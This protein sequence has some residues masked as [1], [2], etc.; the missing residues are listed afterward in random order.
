MVRFEEIK[1]LIAEGL[2]DRAIVRALRCRREKVAEI[3]RGDAP[4]PSRPKFL[5][6][7]LWTEQVPWAEVI[8]ELSLGHPLKMI[9]EEKAQALTTYPN[10]WKQFYRKYPQYLKA[11]VTLREFNPGERCEVDY[12]GDRIEWL[13]LKNGQVHEAAVFV[14]TLGFSQLFF[15][16]AA[17]DMKSRNWLTSHRRMFEAFGGV[18]H[19]TVPDCLKQGVTK[20]HLY[21]P[22]LNRSYAELAAHYHTAIIPARPA[23]PKDKAI[24]EGAVKILMRYFKW[25]HRRRTFTSISEVNQALAQVVERINRKPHTRFRIS[26]LERFEK[27]ERGQLKPLPEHPFDSIEWKEARL[28]PDCHLSVDSA[29]Y[30]A[31][32]IHRNKKLRVK[33]T[34]FHVEIYCELERIAIHKRDRHKSGNRVTDPEHLPPNSRAYR[35]ATP[36]HLL[37]QARFIS[38][39]LY[40]LVNE[41]FEADALGHLRRVQGLIRTCI[42]EINESSRENALPRIEKAIQQMRRFQKYRVSYFQ[43][44]LRHLKK[45]TKPQEDREISRLPDNPMLRYASPDTGAI[46]S[47]FAGIIEESK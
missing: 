1:R 23:H 26:R 3:R 36:Q 46:Q 43:E 8:N 20:C 24:V 2:S 37:S 18:P 33:I 40:T 16:W 32:H 5:P 21:D 12:A 13:D 44:T 28:H 10:F 25:I 38:Q 45:I 17:D 47:V 34:E 4:D 22:D 14:G 35:E 11:S 39:A 30:S 19:V 9:W 7:P 42:H 6:G 27:T 31:P 41:L 15:A 29:F